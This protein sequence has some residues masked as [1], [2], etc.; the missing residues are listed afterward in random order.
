MPLDTKRLNLLITDDRIGAMDVADY[1]AHHGID[2]KLVSKHAVQIHPD[3][4]EKA[5]ELGERYTWEWKPRAA[6][7]A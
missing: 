7:K 2:A 1:L 3:H 5:L 4:H 6:T